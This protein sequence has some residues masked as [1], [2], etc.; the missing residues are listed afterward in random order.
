MESEASDTSELSTDQVRRLVQKANRK[1]KKRAGGF[2]AMGLSQA[3]FNGIARKGYK[4]PTPIQRKAIPVILSG[5]DIVAMARTGSGKTAAFLIPLLERLK[6]HQDTGARA[7]LLS[8]T[9]ELAMQTLAFT[10]DVCLHYFCLHRR[11]LVLYIKIHKVYAWFS[12][13]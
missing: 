1:H 3:V 4:A 2:Q 13:H 9:R 6:R 8:P 11:S 5:R 12:V 10:K 7:L